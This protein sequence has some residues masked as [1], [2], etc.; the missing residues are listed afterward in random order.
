MMG[1]SQEK[2]G[3][4]IGLTF[5]QVQKYERGA[6]RVSAGTLHALTSALD[7][8]VSFFFDDMGDGAKPAP[9]DSEMVDRK[10]LELQ[11]AYGAIEDET[12]RSSILDLVKSINVRERVEEG[13]GV[14]YY[15][16]VDGLHR[17][18]ASID[19]GLMEIP[20]HI[21]D[22]SED[23]LLEAQLI[24]N[25]QKVETRPVEYS[26]QLRRIL[27]LNPMMNVGEL[28]ARCLIASPC[29]AWFR[30]CAVILP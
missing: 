4:A 17:Y 14:K 22:L 15:E 16:L 5:Q 20:V 19:A 1:M 23:M 7:V 12:L 10:S 25:I 6:N 18:C 27:A 11:K 8:P 3:E 30:S 21:V 9:S 2:L 26:N 29:A 28:A 24:A 13:T